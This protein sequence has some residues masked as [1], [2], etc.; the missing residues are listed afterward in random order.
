MSVR[1]SRY[2]VGFS[3]GMFIIVI[4]SVHRHFKSIPCHFRVFTLS[5]QFL[6]DELLN[7]AIS[8]L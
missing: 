5:F 1:I 4:N 2:A 8:D 6:I 3:I 7:N